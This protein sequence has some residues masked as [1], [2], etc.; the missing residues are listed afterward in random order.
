LGIEYMFIED[1]SSQVVEQ[2]P[3]SLEY[4]RGLED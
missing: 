1:E 3:Q 2:V 4:L